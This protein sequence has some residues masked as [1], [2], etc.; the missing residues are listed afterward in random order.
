MSESIFT[1]YWK[2]VA[3]LIEGKPTKSKAISL[4]ENPPA[5]FDGV[6]VVKRL[7]TSLACDGW[8]K[9]SGKNWAWRSEIQ[10]YQTLSPEVALEREIIVTDTTNKWTYQ[11]S[12]TSG[13]QGSYLNKRRAIDLVTQM[14]HNS[15]AFIELKV[16]SDNPLYAAF[17]ILS[18]ALAYQ[19]ARENNWQGAGVHNVMDAQVVSLIV[20]G[21]GRWYEYKKGRAHI[22]RSKFDFDWLAIALGKGLNTLAGASPGMSFSFE[23]FADLDDPKLTAVG[24]IRQATKW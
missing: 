5:Q 8:T 20:L 21:P 19:Y 18:Y 11:M 15:Y 16:D 6:A 14:G 23:E 24:I 2:E 1:N 4:N 9:S 3:S 12:T 17:E 10:P 22:Q 13:I 7:Y